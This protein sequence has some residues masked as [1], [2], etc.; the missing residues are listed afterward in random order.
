MTDT[1]MEEEFDLMNDTQDRGGEGSRAN[2]N[3]TIE[4]YSLLH[5]ASSCG[6]D[7]I[8]TF[9]LAEC[10]CLPDILL[11]SSGEKWSNKTCETPLHFAVNSNS[12]EIV[13]ILI[14]KIREIVSD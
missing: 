3:K 7:R 10:R 2:Q 4:V 5:Y 9:V 11:E 14:D 1:D 8:F 12:I 13:R 6:D